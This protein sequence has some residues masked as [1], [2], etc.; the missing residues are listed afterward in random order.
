MVP[1][2]AS[3]R[4]YAYPSDVWAAG[5]VLVE[6]L[7]GTPAF[8]AATIP[9]LTDRILAGNLTAELPTDDAPTAALPEPEA[10]EA[11]DTDQFLRQLNAL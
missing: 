1:L 5:C 4:P 6:L 9:A 8:T 7:S 10:A 11:D 3:G 2:R